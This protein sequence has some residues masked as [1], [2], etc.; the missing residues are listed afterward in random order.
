MILLDKIILVFVAV[1][2]LSGWLKGF[3]RSLVGP[4]AFICC[5]LSAVIFYDLNQNILMAAVIMFAGTIALAL[6]LSLLLWISLRSINKEYR[7]KIFLLS[8]ICGA[9]TNVAWQANILF[10][11]II[12]FSLCPLEEGALT[13]LQRQVSEST[14]VSYYKTKIVNQDVRLQALVAS[15]ESLRDPQ[16]VQAIA[17]TDK[18]KAFQNDPNVQAFIHDPELQKALADNDSL[19]ILKSPSLRKLVT[20]DGSMSTFTKLTEM[21][22]TRKLDQLSGRAGLKPAA[23]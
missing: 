15:L 4:V 23:R 9:T 1:F 13:T 5:F 3:L 16:Q 6:C 2:F 14:M 11:G 8:R 19:K 20:D 12:F 22:Y 17:Q 7:G 10:F 18:Y 21:V